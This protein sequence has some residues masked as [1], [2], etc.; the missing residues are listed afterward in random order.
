[1][2]DAE[3]HHILQE[4]TLIIGSANLN[5]GVQVIEQT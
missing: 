2:W 3:L 1:V 4:A 5:P